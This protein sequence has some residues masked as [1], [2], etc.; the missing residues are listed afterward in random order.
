MEDDASPAINGDEMRRTTRASSRQPS[1][2]ERAS[3]A[4]NGD[5]EESEENFPK[6]YKGLSR[7]YYELMQL[8]LALKALSDWRKAEDDVLT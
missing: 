8:T 4:R 2:S 3:A 7:T 6:L 5:Q 1:G